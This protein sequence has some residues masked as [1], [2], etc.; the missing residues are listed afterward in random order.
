VERTRTLGL[1]VFWRMEL[2][3]DAMTTR[4]KVQLLRMSAVTQIVGVSEETIRRWVRE[5]RFPRGIKLGE[6]AVG[7]D[8]ADVVAFIEQRKAAGAAQ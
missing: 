1:F 6:R 3:D 5:G 7:W 2:G 4:R 8:A